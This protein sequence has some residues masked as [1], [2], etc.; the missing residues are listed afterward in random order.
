MTGPLDVTPVEL[1]DLARRVDGYADQIGEITP[2]GDL[3][4]LANALQGSRVAAIASTLGARLSQ[5][6]E[7]LSSDLSDEA[8][9]L[10]TATGVIVTADGDNAAMFGGR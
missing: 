6:A 3:T 7:R 1:T 5:S 10:R 9:R 2:E 4:T 8:G